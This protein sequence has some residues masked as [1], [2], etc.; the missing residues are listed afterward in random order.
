MGAELGQWTEW[1]FDNELDW[2]QLQ[3]DSPQGLVRMTGDLNSLYKNE[4]AL[5]ELEFDWEGFEWIDCNNSDASTLSFIRKSKSGEFIVVVANF[6]PIVRYDFWVGV[7]KS[8]TY[9]VIFNSDSSYYSGSNVGQAFVKA[10]A[11]ECQ[12][13]PASMQITLPPLALVMF[14][15]VKSDE[16]QS[17]DEDLDDVSDESKETDESIK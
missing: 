17:P 6:T 16:P 5:H 15:L 10:T 3:Y 7:P 11:V 12:G 14:K 8:G 2:N 9:E 1:D 13:R 4:P